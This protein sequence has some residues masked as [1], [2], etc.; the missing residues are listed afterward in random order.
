MLR[1]VD[2][3]LDFVEGAYAGVEALVVLVHYH[4]ECVLELGVRFGEVG[5]LV[6]EAEGGGVFE[7]ER[8]FDGDAGRGGHEG[9][10][11]FY[12]SEDFYCSISSQIYTS[13]VVYIGLPSSMYCLSAY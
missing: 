5:V 10:V 6:G 11:L 2:R 8:D 3:G 4:F 7:L 13:E 12:V 9:P 1:G